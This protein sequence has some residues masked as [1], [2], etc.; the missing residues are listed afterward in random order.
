[1][2]HFVLAAALLAAWYPWGRL[3]VAGRNELIPQTTAARH[4]LK[5]PW[6]T[7]IQMDRSRA[8][9][10]HVVLHEGT[11]YVQTDR[12]MIHAIDAETGATL[13]AKQVGRPDHPSVTPAAGRDLLA[14]V[15]GSRLYV[16]NRYN[17][18][19]LYEI[20]LDGVPGA[21]PCISRLRA[22]VPMIGGMLVAYRLEALTDPLKELGKVNENPTAEEIA[23]E[24]ED[25]RENLRLRQEFIRPLL[26]QSVGRALVQPL[27]TRQTEAEEFV[28]WPT[29][30]GY[31]NIGRIDLGNEDRL[32]IKYRLE[33]GAGIASRPTYLPPDPNDPTDSGII[34]AAS[35]D[36]YVHAIHERSGE[37]MWR[38]STGDP[39]LQPVVVIEDRVYVATQL[40]GM[41]CINAEDGTQVWWTPQIRQFVAASRERVYAADNLGRILTL[42]AETGS[43]L[44]T[45][46]AEHLPI[47]LINSDT[48]RLYLATRT[49]LIQCLH[50]QE[51]SDPILHGEARKKKAEEDQ[52]AI[53]QKSI[54]D[55]QPPDEQD[56][57]KQVGP[58]ADDDPYN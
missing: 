42:R 33:T 10:S 49:G 1:M 52:S 31:L 57:P 25:R 37:S 54:E 48:D 58:A 21:G 18:D 26:C 3:A 53:Q 13:W 19:L 44:D 47:K 43:R 46:A 28:V 56:T 32:A 36:G 7:Q 50:E 4:G 15:N 45:I 55:L 2:R 29:D 6:F 5:R 11:L 51:L 35:R 27:V 17:G 9:V 16:C 22:Y 41:F 8:R 14:V 30:R 38:F 40:G 34:F 12:A 20:Q 23:A 24:E 39:I